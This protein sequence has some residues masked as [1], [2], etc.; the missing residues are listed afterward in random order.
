MIDVASGTYPLVV[1]AAG[2]SNLSYNI[3]V[4]AIVG[5]SPTSGTVGTTVTITGHGFP[6]NASG[7]LTFTGEPDM[8]I[9][10][11]GLGVFTRAFVLTVGTGG[12]RQAFATIG[13]S[14][15]GI[16]FFDITPVLSIGATAT[17]SS[18]ASVPASLYLSQAA[19]ASGV[20]VTVTSSSP[21]VTVNGLS[22]TSIYFSPGRTI[23]S[24]TISG[25]S[26]GAATLTITSSD[27]FLANAIFNPF[28]V[29]VQ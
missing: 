11:N 4:S 7:T 13:S 22:S 15:S 21:A 9:T 19:P 29:T 23:A 20:T 8:T 28:A 1:T 3:P 16:N 10:S 6:A 17:I 14:Q 26:L 18:G 5:E 25:A 24:F 2:V 27:P 12:G